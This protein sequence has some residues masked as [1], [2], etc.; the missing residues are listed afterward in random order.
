[1]RALIRY[2]FGRVAALC[3][4]LALS[5]ASGVVAQESQ[6]RPPQDRAEMEQRHLQM[7]CEKAIDLEQRWRLQMH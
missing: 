5:G 7:H 4:M 3:G 2:R 1:M 6:R